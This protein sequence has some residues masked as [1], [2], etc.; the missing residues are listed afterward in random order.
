LAEGAQELLIGQEFD[1]V[2]ESDQLDIHFLEAG[3]YSVN[4][5]SIHRAQEVGQKNDLGTGQLLS[6]KT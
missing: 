5:I 4:R 1:V 2:V 3:D 6:P